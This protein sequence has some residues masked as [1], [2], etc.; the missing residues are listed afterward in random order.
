MLSPSLKGGTEKELCNS[1]SAAIQAVFGA[2]PIPKGWHRKATQ[3]F[4]N[5]S[6]SAIPQ[7][8]NYRVEQSKT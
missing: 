3:Q 6:N 2:F 4:C 1:S 7:S 5:S 8:R